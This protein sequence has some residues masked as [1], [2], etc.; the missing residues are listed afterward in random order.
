MIAVF[1]GNALI[2]VC[3]T[4]QPSFDFPRRDIGCDR[5]NLLSLKTISVRLDD[6]DA[7]LAQLS[8]VLT[9]MAS[10]A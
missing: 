6:D 3:G 2:T 8:L 1:F 9:T 7:G 5:G 10:L 4:Y